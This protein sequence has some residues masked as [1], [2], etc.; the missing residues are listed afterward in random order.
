MGKKKGVK[1]KDDKPRDY[2][3]CQP[4]EHDRKANPH[5]MGTSARKGDRYGK[6]GKK[7]NKGGSKGKHRLL[8]RM[9]F[10]CST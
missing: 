6:H 2:T 8:L 3:P 5:R 10:E 9:L 1:D 4:K 7:K